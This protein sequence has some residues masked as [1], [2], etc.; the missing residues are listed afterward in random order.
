MTH[1]RN[2]GGDKIMEDIKGIIKTLDPEGKIK[3][4]QTEA[5]EWWDR[6]RIANKRKE[7]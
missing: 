2:N 7:K 6:A 1:D 4:T 3:V 5:L